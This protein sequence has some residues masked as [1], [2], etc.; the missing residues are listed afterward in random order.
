[1][2]IPALCRAHRTPNVLTHRLFPV[3]LQRQIVADFPHTGHVSCHVARKFNLTG[4]GNSAYQCDDTALGY[5][6]YAVD[7][8]AAR[9]RKLANDHF[10]ECPV[11][12]F[13]GFGVGRPDGLRR[14]LRTGSFGLCERDCRAIWLR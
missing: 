2:Y 13:R 8:K 10:P 14:R 6:V 12:G 5:D 11:G 7:A 9:T 4:L 3:G 1:M